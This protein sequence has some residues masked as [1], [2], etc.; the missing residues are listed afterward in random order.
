VRERQFSTCFQACCIF[1]ALFLALLPA[2]AGLDDAYQKDADYLG[3][4]RTVKTA[5]EEAAKAKADPDGTAYATRRADERLSYTKAS[6]SLA[7]MGAKVKVYQALT[8]MLTARQQVTVSQQRKDTTALQYEAAQLKWQAG[9]ISAQALAQAK[10][11]LARAEVA[12]ATD[13]SLLLG[14]EFRLKP[15]GEASATP[16]AAPAVLETAK[17]TVEKHPLVIKAQ[18]DVNEAQ[19][20]V[21]LSKGPDTAPL[22]LAAAQRTLSTAQDMLKDT[23]RIQ[24]ETLDAAVRRYNAAR[25]SLRVAQAGLTLTQDAHDAAKKRFESGAVSRVALL[26]AQV[27][28]QESSLAVTKALAELWLSSFAV[29]QATGGTQ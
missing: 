22:D 15:Y 21:D 16:L 28:Q 23:S 7:T 12:L 29:L 9:A 14:A 1:F 26:E 24:T 25:E 20:A 6:L 2:R 13:R 18:N 3:A 27:A 8:D 4:Q 17:L 10:D 11:A 5:E 19:R